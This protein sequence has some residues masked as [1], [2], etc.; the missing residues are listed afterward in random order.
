MMIKKVKYK[1]TKYQPSLLMSL[2]PSK[3][4]L[5]TLIFT[6]HKEDTINQINQ[7]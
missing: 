4:T 5:K 7:I 6:D 3:I 1:T 2:I